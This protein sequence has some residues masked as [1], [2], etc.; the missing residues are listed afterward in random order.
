MTRW[1]ELGMTAEEY[2]H[3][4]WTDVEILHG[5]ISQDEYGFWVTI[6][7]RFRAG[8]YD[9]AERGCVLAAEFTVQHE[10]AIPLKRK[11]IAWCS[12]FLGEP[13]CDC[14]KCNIVRRVLVTL[15]SQLADLLKG[16]K[17]QE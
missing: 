12:K 4:R 17:E 6:R 11:E 16:W 1:E 10:E 13:Y 2:L 14:E 7:G 9:S 3:S 15:E 5:L 8:P